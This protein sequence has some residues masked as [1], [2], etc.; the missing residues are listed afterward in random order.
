M[1]HVGAVAVVIIHPARKLRTIRPAA[2]FI[3]HACVKKTAA[4]ETVPLQIIDCF[5][6]KS[7]TSGN[8]VR[9]ARRVPHAAAETN[10]IGGNRRTGGCMVCQLHR[11]ASRIQPRLKVKLPQRKPHETIFRLIHDNC[12]VASRMMNNILRLCGPARVSR[13][14]CIDPVKTVRRKIRRPFCRGGYAC[15]AGICQTVDTAVIERVDVYAHPRSRCLL[16]ESPQRG[17]KPRACFN[18]SPVGRV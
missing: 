17:S 13:P 18:I 16:L 5:L 7:R 2:R 12:R 9:L 15:S 1:S 14:T 10:G 11:A 6:L 3:I 4:S 8:A